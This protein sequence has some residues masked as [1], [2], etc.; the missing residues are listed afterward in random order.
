MEQYATAE[1]WKNWNL[2]SKYYGWYK[3]PKQ[4]FLNSEQLEPITHYIKKF[5]WFEQQAIK[6]FPWFQQQAM[7][8]W[9]RE[10]M[11]KS[12]RK[13]GAY[14]FFLQLPTNAAIGHLERELW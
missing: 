10:N 7:Q 3:L 2:R 4:E 9:G 5:L 11:T 8:G 6:K 13:V 1:T 14:N 12:V